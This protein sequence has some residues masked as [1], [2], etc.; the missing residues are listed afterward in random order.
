[1][2][3]RTLVLYVAQQ[4]GVTVEQSKALVELLAETAIQEVK[5]SGMF[6]I[7][8]IGRIVIIER[9]LRLGPSSPPTQE[10]RI[11]TGSVVK[12]RVSKTVQDAI[13]NEEQLG[14]GQ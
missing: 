11:K 12:F 1:M 8:G 7:P 13:A 5:N 14:L 6:A 3:K 4:I 10:I 9:P 2:T